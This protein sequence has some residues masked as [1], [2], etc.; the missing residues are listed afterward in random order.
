MA[1]LAETS[2]RD[3]RKIFAIYNLLGPEG[4]VSMHKLR[5]F[6]HKKIGFFGSN[7]STHTRGYFVLQQSPAAD[8][9]KCLESSS[10]NSYFDGDTT[11]KFSTFLCQPKN[12][13]YFNGMIATSQ[14][15]K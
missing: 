2:V 14:A 3:K 1:L 13:T 12:Y 15:E 6:S 4:V 11:S 5:I 7:V 9:S 10:F 8:H